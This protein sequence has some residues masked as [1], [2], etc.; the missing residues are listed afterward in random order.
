MCSYAWPVGEWVIVLDYNCYS[1]RR[2]DTRMCHLSVTLMC[3]YR[4][5]PSPTQESMDEG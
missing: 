4:P 1:N 2:N 3:P 5:T